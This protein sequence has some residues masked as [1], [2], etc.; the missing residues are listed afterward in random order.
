MRV[1][2]IDIGV[3]NLAHCVLDEA[4][5]IYE[6]DVVDLT[7]SSG[8]TCYKCS[9]KATC[10]GRRA[11][12]KKHCPQ[13]PTLSGTKEQLIAKCNEFSIPVPENA[14][15]D[16]VHTLLSAYREEWGTKSITKKVAD[17]SPVF[18]AKRL[19]QE[20][21]KF[22]GIDQ[23]VVENQI[24]PLAA[25]MK[26]MQGM[27]IQYWTMK[28]VDVQVVSACNKLKLFGEAPET[29]AD[30]KRLGIEHTRRLLAEWGLHTNFETHKKKDDL[31]D[32]FLQGLWFLVTIKKVQFQLR[33]T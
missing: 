28:G 4:G 11:Y 25:R 2:S 26:G 23:V 7:G 22:T 30:R 5:K 29:Y 17:C 32:T 14:T 24:G 27:V 31:A 20:Y 21:D 3:R 10:A 1:L 18:L 33:C 15:R 6:W 19:M 9:K 12:C 13:V 16:T 8:E